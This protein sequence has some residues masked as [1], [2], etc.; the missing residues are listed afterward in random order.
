M[1]K[2]AIFIFI[3][4]S[5]WAQAKNDTKK[6]DKFIKKLMK[7]MTLEEKLGQL[8]LIT[9]G[10][11]ILTGSVVST[12]VEEKIAQGKVGGLF[13][14]HGPEK[15]G[16]AQKLAMSSRL[17]IPLLFGSDVIHGYETTFP[18]PLGTSFSWDLKLI[19]ESARIAANEAS[20]KNKSIFVRGDYQINDDWTVYMSA[21]VTKVYTFG[22]YAPVPG[23]VRV[24]DGTL[25]DINSNQELIDA[26][27]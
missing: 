9:P 1:R 26:H 18:I 14:I 13:G 8:N 15:I 17:K 4:L 19:E 20:V 24:E 16:K 10:D 5:M 2:I 7:E 25:Q 23:V 21:N 27:G 11:G 12:G 22:R 6:M 3:G